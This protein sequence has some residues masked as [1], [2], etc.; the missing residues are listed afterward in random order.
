MADVFFKNIR[1]PSAVM[2]LLTGAAKVLRY[3][4]LASFGAGAVWT[5]LSFWDLKRGK[6]LRAGW[7][8]ILGVLAGTTFVAGPGAG[9]AVLW[10]WREE[11]LAARASEKSLKSTL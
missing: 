6:I 9:M 8:R 4:H 7:C 1:N 2:P 5:L 11:V 3:D 10:W